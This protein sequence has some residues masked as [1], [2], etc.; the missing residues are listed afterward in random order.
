MA[1]PT[2]TELTAKQCRPCEGGIPALSG[3]EVEQYS[4]AVPN[5][6]V[7]ND[8]KRIA[9]SWRMK[10]FRTALDLF[11]RVGEIAEQEDHHPDLHL[12]GYR[13]VTIELST[14]AIGGLSENDFILA[15]KIDRVPVALKQG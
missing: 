12:V 6:K 13:N 1:I 8:G 14:H 5:W 15:A 7:S 10:D 9:R 11:Q 3:A 4:S 2:T